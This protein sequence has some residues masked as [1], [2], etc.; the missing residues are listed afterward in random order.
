MWKTNGKYEV[1][2]L[3]LWEDIITWE[4]YHK[5]I[6]TY[7]IISHTNTLNI[8][9]KLLKFEMRNVEPKVSYNGRNAPNDIWSKDVTSLTLSTEWPLIHCKSAKLPWHHDIELSFWSL[10]FFFFVATSFHLS[11]FC[12]DITLIRC[13]IDITL[14]RCLKGLKSQKS[15]CVSIF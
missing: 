2:V 7:Q 3:P 4:A 9:I 10:S 13:L 5:C 1:W 6:K 8:Y 11:V 14:I 12:P 15:L